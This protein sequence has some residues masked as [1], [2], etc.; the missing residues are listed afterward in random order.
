[1][2][3]THT[4]VNTPSE[5]YYILLTDT[6]VSVRQHTQLQAPQSRTVILHLLNEDINVRHN[7]TAGNF[8]S[9]TIIFDSISDDARVRHNTPHTCKHPN[10]GLFM[11]IF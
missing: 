5:D 8:Q 7:A 4:L 3:Y 11:Y 1:M 6:N 9:R 10:R 2:L